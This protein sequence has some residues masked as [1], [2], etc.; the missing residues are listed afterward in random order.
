MIQKSN[1]FRKCH[2]YDKFHGIGGKQYPLKFSTF[3]LKEKPMQ[4][5]VYKSYVLKHVSS[6]YI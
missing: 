6:K 2:L 4:S 1:C 5:L 3:F